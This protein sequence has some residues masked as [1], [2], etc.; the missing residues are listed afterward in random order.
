M[1]PVPHPLCRPLPTKGGSLLV[2]PSSPPPS[3]PHPSRPPASPGYQQFKNFP[4]VSHPAIPRAFC[5]R[6]CHWWNRA[7]TCDAHVDNYGNRILLYG[8]VDS[9]AALCCCRHHYAAYRY[10]DHWFH[11]H[12]ATSL[13]RWHGGTVARWHDVTVPLKHAHVCMYV[14]LL[15]VLVRSTYEPTAG[16]SVQRLELPSRWYIAVPTSST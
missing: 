10:G 11:N 1:S 12:S 13:S 3:L 15:V 8:Y 14:L 2:L 5:C 7:T 16:A 4:A 6:E 9:S